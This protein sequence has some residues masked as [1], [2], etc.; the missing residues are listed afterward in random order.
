MQGKVLD[1]LPTTGPLFPRLAELTASERA[2]WFR[3]KLDAVKITGISLHSYR[4]AWAER[5]RQAGYPEQYAMQALGHHCEAVHRSYGKK[6]KVKLPSLEEFES[7]I[8]GIADVGKSIAAIITRTTQAVSAKAWLFKKFCRALRRPGPAPET[9]SLNSASPLRF[10]FPRL[11]PLSDN[12][13]GKSWRNFPLSS[14]CME[15]NVRWRPCF[16]VICCWTDKYSA[17]FKIWS[18][19]DAHWFVNSRS[20]HN[21]DFGKN[22]Y[23]LHPIANEWPMSQHCLLYMMMVTGRPHCVARKK[24][25]I[26]IPSRGSSPRRSNPIWQS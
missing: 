4:Y 20:V 17:S 2:A 26:T 24:P 21:A 22:Y 25:G 12:L 18:C 7:K 1:G 9:A 11:A 5:A 15:K 16:V 13:K 14:F 23:G 19:R 6:A 8:V 3:H 10:G